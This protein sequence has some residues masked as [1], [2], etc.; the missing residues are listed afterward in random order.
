MVSLLNISSRSNLNWST[1]WLSY[2]SDMLSWSRST[3]PLLTLTL[4]NILSR[5]NTSSTSLPS[6]SLYLLMSWLISSLYLIQSWTNTSIRP[7]R[8][9]YRM[10][11]CIRMRSNLIMRRLSLIYAQYIN[12]I[13]WINFNSLFSFFIEPFLDKKHKRCK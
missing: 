13:V 11:S 3:D 6:A 4:L 5:L 1:S 8:P 2:W 7:Y 10:T 12:L 9:R